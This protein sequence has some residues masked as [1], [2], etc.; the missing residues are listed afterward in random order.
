[1]AKRRSSATPPQQLI[2]PLSAAS[3]LVSSMNVFERPM[4][5]RRLMMYL[6]AFGTMLALSTML[7]LRRAAL[8]ARRADKVHLALPNA[9]VPALDEMP[10]NP[11]DGA[12]VAEAVAATTSKQSVAGRRATSK[13]AQAPPAHP[14]QP[15]LPPAI[16]AGHVNTPA[17]HLSA[18]ELKDDVD[19]FI[20]H[21][22][23]ETA[24][25][26]TA[27]ATG[28]PT[29]A[30][31]GGTA[32]SS[33]GSVS[34][35]HPASSSGSSTSS[36]AGT[37]ATTTGSLTGGKESANATSDELFTAAQASVE[38]LSKNETVKKFLDVNELRTLH[39]L[40]L[41]GTRGDCMTP[42]KGGALFK[43][44]AEAAGADV[45][46]T[47]PLWGAWCLFTSVYR[48]DAIREYINRAH[49]LQQRTEAKAAAVD[50]TEGDGTAAQ[51]PF[52]QNAAT[53]DDV[54]SPEEQT[55]L[56]SNVELVLPHLH[57]SDVRYLAALSLQ[58]SFGDCGPYQ[59]KLPRLDADG[60]PLADAAEDAARLRP[61]TES[62]LKQ[63]ATR[64]EGA[65]WGAWC[66]FSRRKRR[67][68]ATQ[69][70]QRVDLLLVQLAQKVAPGA[71]SGAAPGTSQ[72]AAATT[73]RSVLSPDEA[74][75]TRYALA[76][77]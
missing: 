30:G 45:E 22:D 60:E 7:D 62:L 3:S 68:A 77:P 54:L 70:T 33:P 26:K 31:T 6:A 49:G 66:V 76:E 42:R 12:A 9:A 58:A 18:Q 10:T 29:P 71:A 47:D 15:I 17:S 74:P 59:K 67:L 1:M 4:R 51:P 24:A 11:A 75:T 43:T 37:T 50:S 35:L 65:L 46:R 36:V 61:L 64:A 8:N 38:A 55:K 27:P 44:D 32:P 28:A 73:S 21:V 39:A 13:P 53:L 56:R 19:Q 20:A 41:Q 25:N 72:G 48:S 63:T 23:Q 2:A 14:A 52:D 16:P 69:L 5:R 34:V 40:A 57:E